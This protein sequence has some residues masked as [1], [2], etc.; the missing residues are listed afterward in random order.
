MTA[1][2]M[3][4]DQTPIATGG[5]RLVFEH[6]LDPDLLVKVMRPE[7]VETRYGA[8]TPWYKRRRRYRQYVIFIRE[9][10]EYVASY[11]SHGESLPCA[12]QIAGLVETDLGLGMVMFAA[13][14]ADGKLAPTLATLIETGRFDDSAKIALENFFAELLQ[15][16]LVLADLHERNLV[17]AAGADGKNRFVMIDGTGASGFLPLKTISRTLNRRNKR[18]KIRRLRKRIELRQ[19]RV[20]ALSRPS[21]PPPLQ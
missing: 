7:V 21:D 5:V 16:S 3:L 1:R 20:A 10:S 8:G 19:S 12:V 14:D 18:A 2:L 13:R 17:F 15:S 6:P 4:K 9:I 11:A